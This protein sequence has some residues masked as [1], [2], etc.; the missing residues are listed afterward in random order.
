MRDFLYSEIA[1]THGMNNMPD[2]PDLAIVAGRDSAKINIGWHEIPRR[3]IS[4]F[5]PPRGLLTKL[6]LPNYDGN[7]SGQYAGFP[8]P[9]FTP[10]AGSEQGFGG[11]I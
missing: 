9:A 11:A 4:S 10:P 3:R 6:G 1:A 8:K 2:D 7:H 5:V